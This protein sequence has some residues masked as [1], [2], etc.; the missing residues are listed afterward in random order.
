LR[1]RWIRSKGDG[2]AGIIG[3][4]VEIASGES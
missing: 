2:V 4:L 3:G 1:S